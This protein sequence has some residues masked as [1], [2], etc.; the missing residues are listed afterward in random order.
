[1]ITKRFFDAYPEAKDILPVSSPNAVMRWTGEEYSPLDDF[2]FPSAEKE[3]FAWHREHLNETREKNI[4]HKQKIYRKYTKMYKEK[5]EKLL[6]F[7]G[8]KLPQKELK[9]YLLLET[10][11]LHIL[12]RLKKIFLKH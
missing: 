8:P 2:N 12:L 1:M 9:T 10:N 11:F 5:I 6:N 7:M 4:L 3:L